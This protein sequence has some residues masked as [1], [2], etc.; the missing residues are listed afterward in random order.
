MDSFGA[1]EV[2]GLI[3]FLLAVGSFVGNIVQWKARQN[4]QKDLRSHLQAA[5]T[6]FCQITRRCDEIIKTAANDSSNF[7][8]KSTNLTYSIHGASEAARSSINSFSRE[9]LGILP[10]DE[11]PHRPIQEPLPTIGK[12]QAETE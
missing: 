2:I 6:H 4:L 9:H 7:L 5:Y 10:R 12:R 8:Q 11:H 3:S 1:T